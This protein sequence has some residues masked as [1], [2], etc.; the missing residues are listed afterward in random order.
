MSEPQAPRGA[1]ARAAAFVAESWRDWELYAIIDR[2][3]F[4]PMHPPLVR[5]L[6]PT[7]VRPNQLSASTIL[8]GVL[9][10]AGYATF[11]RT[12]IAVGGAFLFLSVLIDGIDGELART[13]P[14]KTETGKVFEVI[15]DPAKVVLSFLGIAVGMTRAD[16]WG[17]LP[18]PFAAPPVAHIWGLCILAGASLAAQVHA[19][20]H[21]VEIYRRCALGF[22]EPSYPNLERVRE[23]YEALR[24]RRGYWLEKAVVPVVLRL[25][26]RSP[27][28][29]P[30][31]PAPA[32]PGYR[33]ALKPYIKTLSFFAG[34]T[35]MI[36]LI[37][38]SFAGVPVWAL[39]YILASDV[40]FLPLL[41]LLARAHRR[42]L[43]AG[44]APGP[45]R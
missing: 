31:P 6:V 4:G 27:R 3:I 39:I 34:G 37:A 33:A 42:A 7:R 32:V 19:R 43:A 11:T 14:E 13:R 1:L 28:P 24:G 22:S 9:A 16:S 40:V 25:S 38:T 17:P 41:P 21:W 2:L 8:C 10:F 44:A 29:A 12:G 18:Y 36:V 20:N 45:L 35:Q 30:P 15:C 23:E 5:L 26:P